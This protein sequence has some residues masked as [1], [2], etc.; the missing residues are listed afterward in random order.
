MSAVQGITEDAVMKSKAAVVYEFN[1]PIVVEEVDVD[2]PRAGEAL[3]KMAATGVC[4]SNWHAI[5]G[6]WPDTPRPFVLGDEGSGTVVEVGEGMTTVAAGDKVV[7]SW[8]PYCRSCFFCNRGNFHLCENVLASR[9]RKGDDTVYSFATISTFTEYVVVPESGLV[10]V[11]P[12]V[13]L[14]QAAV[15]GC[16]VPTG[17]GG[18]RE[19]GGGGAGQ[20]RGRYRPWRRRAQR[21]HGRRHGQRGQYHRSGHTGR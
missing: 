18:R 6:A 8:T 10:P 16:A 11:R 5:S 7:L 12:D 4:H 17:W 19:H 13:P 2:P 9:F 3:V 15:V 20:Y 14:D 21:G 1:A